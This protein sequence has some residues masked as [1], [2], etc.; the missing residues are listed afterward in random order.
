MSEPSNYKLSGSGLSA[1]NGNSGA[2]GRAGNTS[3]PWLLAE[4][5]AAKRIYRKVQHTSALG[6]TSLWWYDG[7]AWRLG[8][9]EVVE[10][11]LIE[12]LSNSATIKPSSTLVDEVI[13]IIGS[14]NWVTENQLKEPPLNLINLRNG[15]LDFETGQ[16]YPHDPQL[17]F[18]SV[19]DVEY[20]P[21]AQCPNFLRFLAEILPP[22]AHPTIQELFGYALYRGNHARR[23]FLFIGSGNNGK[24]ML[25]DILT[26]WIG[27]ENVSNKSLQDLEYNRF[28]V[29]RLLGKHV[30]VS[31]DLPQTPLMKSEVLRALT[32]GDRLEAERKHRDSFSFLP[33]AKLVFSTNK[34]PPV[35]EDEVDA[36][37]KR[38][39]II[40][41]PYEFEDDPGKRKQIL[42]S[43]TTD[44]EKSGILNWALEGLRRLL[45]SGRF[46]AD[47]GDSAKIRDRWMREVNP[48]YDFLTTFVERDPTG[49]I[50]KKNLWTRYL[51][52]REEQGLPT[53]ERQNEFSQLIQ[54]LFRA[55]SKRVRI[56][57]E[58]HHV[59]VGIRWK[60]QDRQEQEP[61]DVD[62]PSNYKRLGE[63]E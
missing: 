20:K 5:L 53:I 54:A 39:I 17:W 7:A 44:E 60:D 50:V 14:K 42:D 46:T 28:S 41:F 40:Q 24:S 26:Q 12:V 61:S 4:E 63:T 51:T 57:G 21:D 19:I 8:A 6:A 33:F 27:E 43:C 10:K 58:L 16:L 2:K 13:R 55:E 30:N 48:A 25:L 22:E 49:A 32:G 36:F 1:G 62:D 9:E 38:W 37:F 56:Q 15:V 23:A 59:W 29:A 18:T 11:D 47:E 31:A 52:W 3:D 35:K 45:K 34:L